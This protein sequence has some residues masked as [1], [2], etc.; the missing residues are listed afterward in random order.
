[1]TDSDTKRLY[2]KMEAGDAKLDT[3]I[4]QLRADMHRHVAEISSN[5]NSISTSTAVISEQFKTVAD[6]VKK[7]PPIPPRPCAYF[8]K[9]MEHHE[10]ISMLWLR[11][12]VGMLASGLLGAMGA[13]WGFIKIK[14]GG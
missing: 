1:M 14:K 12:I 11:T 7:I 3:K 13:L 9:H 5:L 4:E 10:N 8:E 6:D 2:D